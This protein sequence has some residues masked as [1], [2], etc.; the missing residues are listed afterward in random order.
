MIEAGGI[1]QTMPPAVFHFI[2]TVNTVRGDQQIRDRRS[3]ISC[4]W[5]RANL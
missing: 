1:V 2:P 5:P 3:A 4:D